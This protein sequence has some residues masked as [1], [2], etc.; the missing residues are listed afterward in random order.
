MRGGWPVGVATVVVVVGLAVI[1][2]LIKIRWVQRLAPLAIVAVVL[3]ELVVIAPRGFY[4]PRSDP[5][6]SS[7]LTKFLVAHTRDGSRVF[8][9]DGVLYPDAAGPYGLSDPRVLDAL[10][11][12]RY[13]TYLKNFVSHGIND[14]FT[15]TGPSESAPAVAA[16]PMFNLLGVRYVIYKDLTGNAPPAW[17]D[18]QYKLV[19]HG[20]GARVYE[21]TT[22]FHGRSWRHPC[23]E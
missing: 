1:P 22:R 8:S 15:G 6:P 5:Y 20:D 13:W 2:Q 9:S 4:A 3:L 19:F 7:A 14:R 10:Y 16:N 21:N 23:T 12:D 11:P 18:P 17:S